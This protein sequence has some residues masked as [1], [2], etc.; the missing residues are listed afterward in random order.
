MSDVFDFS[1]TELGELE[2]DNDSHD[3]LSQTD[4]ELRIQMAICRIKSVSNNWYIDNIGANLEELIGKAC[5]KNNAN[6]N[7][8]GNG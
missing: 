2:I 1:L 6:S 5:N 4:N 3:L 8:N 7:V